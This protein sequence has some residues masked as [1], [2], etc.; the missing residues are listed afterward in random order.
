MP[1]QRA[2]VFGATGSHLHEGLKQIHSIPHD[3]SRLDNLRQKHLPLPKHPSHALHPFHQR[4]LNHTHSLAIYLNSLRNIFRQSLAP[5][6]ENRIPEPFSHRS[7]CLHLDF[8]CRAGPRFFPGKH[9]RR[10]VYKPFRR[11]RIPVKYHIL[12]A[13]Q[14]LRLDL[15]IDLQHGRVH[16]GHVE[17][18]LDGMV[19]ESRMHGLAHS[20]VASERKRKV[21]HSAGSQ[22]S[23]Q[24]RLDPSHRLDKVHC[25]SCVF[26]NPGTDGKYVHVE[27]YIFRRHSSFLSQKPVCPFAYFDLSIICGCLTLLVEGHD[28]HS[29]SQLSDLPGLCH[30]GLRTLLQTDGIHD[31]LSLC[32]L[33]TGKNRLPVRRINHQ[34]SLCHS[35]VIGYA[36]DESFH[37]PC[38]VQHSVVHVYVYDRG[39]VLDLLCCNL[40]RLVIFA[41]S[42]ESGELAGARHIGPLTDIR[43]VV[44]PKVHP[45]S[46]QTAHCQAPVR[47]TTLISG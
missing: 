33:Q 38:A 46:F 7:D 35:R 5:S 20:I 17:T 26:P 39:P 25:I 29:R 30:E 27:Y 28:H 43:E 18:C 8:R 21:G 13:L 37:L 11:L 22:S 6:F 2:G 15:V 12:H 24:V 42:Y 14:Q 4:S 40:Q 3:L 34:G 47:E 1:S 9:F 36:S 41:G 23:R 45:D 31:A 19:Q 32:V 44:L 10:L 16:D